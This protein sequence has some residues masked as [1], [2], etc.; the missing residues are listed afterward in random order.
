MTFAFG[1]VKDFRPV[2]DHDDGVLRFALLEKY[3]NGGTAASREE[4]ISEIKRIRRLPNVGMAL[5]TY[6]KVNT[7][8]GWIKERGGIG[9]NV[10]W[11]HTKFM[12]VDPVGRKPVTVTGSANWS[13]P[14][15]NANDENM[16][17]IRGDTRVA[18]IYFGEF[19]RIFAHHRFRESIR[20][21][22]ERHGSL[23]GWKPGDLFDRP[24]KWVP[25]HYRAGSE[26]A[27][28]REYFSG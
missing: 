10:N 5:G 14:S 26:H 21:H 27:I 8:D 22:L 6:I 2:F 23:Q 7:I 12:L 3:A 18:D 28:R 19:M 4:A 13:M 9:T 24:S 16:V 15:V 11:V 1:I 20:I 25:M 17:V